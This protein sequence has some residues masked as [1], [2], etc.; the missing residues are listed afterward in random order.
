MGDLPPTQNTSY[1]G[2]DDEIGIPG[3]VR[4]TSIIEPPDGGT[5]AEPTAAALVLSALA[6][7]GL[8]RTRR[9]GARAAVPA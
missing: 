7:L 9:P 4:L 1:R 5:V 6:L 3:T 2:V 8:G